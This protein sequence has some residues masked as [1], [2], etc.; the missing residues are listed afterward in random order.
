MTETSLPEL[1]NLDTIPADK[2]NVLDEAAALI[3]RLA[4]P[5][6]EHLA[7]ELSARL[8]ELASKQRNQVDEAKW[9]AKVVKLSDDLDDKLSIDWRTAIDD[10]G[11]EYRMLVCHLE[12]SGEIDNVYAD[13]RQPLGPQVASELRRIA[14][15]YTDLASKLEPEPADDFLASANSA[16]LH[17]DRFELDGKEQLGL[18]YEVRGS[19]IDG[20]AAQVVLGKLLNAFGQKGGE[21]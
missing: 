13:G 8:Q 14:G 11:E 5:A 4:T 7:V 20:E 9:M 15:I 17:L 1:S 6:E 19:I 2:Y 21:S 16:E 18:T 12:D 10:E 3:D